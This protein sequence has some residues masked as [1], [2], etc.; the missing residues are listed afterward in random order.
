MS[1]RH[2]CLCAR[3]ASMW[4]GRGVAPRVLTS[5]LDENDTCI[6]RVSRLRRVY[7]V[8]SVHGDGEKLNK[9]GMLITLRKETALGT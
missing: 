9:R 4:G 8:D 1:H 6:V 5:A 2:S 7:G 3:D